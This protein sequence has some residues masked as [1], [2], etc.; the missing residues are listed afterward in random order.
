[1]LKSLFLLRV[2]ELLC[3]YLKLWICGR[4]L[5]KPKLLVVLVVSAESIL[6]CL[7]IVW[8]SYGLIKKCVQIRTLRPRFCY[9]SL[10]WIGLDWIGKLGLMCA[11]TVGR[12]TEE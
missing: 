7:K 10:D 8:L 2:D 1:M 5:C 11:V 12:S 3:T 9:F 6:I 4:N